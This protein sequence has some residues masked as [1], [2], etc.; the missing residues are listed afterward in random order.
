MLLFHPK[1]IL[2]LFLWGVRTSTAS[3]TWQTW[4][5]CRFVM[6]LYRYHVSAYFCRKFDCL[7]VRKR[8]ILKIGILNFSRQTSSR[9]FVNNEHGSLL[10]ISI[11]PWVEDIVLIDVNTGWDNGWG[12]KCLVPKILSTRIFHFVK[13]QKTIWDLWKPLKT[14]SN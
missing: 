2:F 3:G 8:H 9:D 1:S 10:G 5:Y 14:N 13:S 12:K 4:W 11:C 7:E 6:K